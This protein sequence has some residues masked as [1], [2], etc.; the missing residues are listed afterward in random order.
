MNA[1]NFAHWLKCIPCKHS[2]AKL[3]PCEGQ[4]VRSVITIASQLALPLSGS[5]VAPPHD[6][7]LPTSCYL[8]EPTLPGKKLSREPSQISRGLVPN[9][10]QTNEIA[11]ML[12]GTC[13]LSYSVSTWV[14]HQFQAGLLG[15]ARLHWLQKRALGLR[16]LTWIIV[17]LYIVTG[18]G[19]GLLLYYTSLTV[20]I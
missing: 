4:H 14:A 1:A 9:R 6:N 12:I 3:M 13:Y 10:A 8:P 11:T 2:F 18:W 15:V 17:L 16:N 5:V 20:D 19:L 7:P